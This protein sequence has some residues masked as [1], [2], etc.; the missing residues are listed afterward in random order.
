VVVQGA[1]ELVARSAESHTGRYLREV[2]LPAEALA[3]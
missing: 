1:P 3:G 2:L